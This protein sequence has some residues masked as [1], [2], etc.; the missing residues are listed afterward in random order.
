MKKDPLVFIGH[1][2]EC[3]DL[4]QQ[5]TKNK[6]EDDFLDSS[7]LQDAV[8]KRIE[9]IGEAAKNL[10][11]SFKVM[12]LEVP[13]KKITGMR[14]KLVH[15]YVGIDFELAWVVVQDDLPTLKKQLQEIKNKS[16]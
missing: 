16:V 5:Y 6:T 2:L 8:V 4:I 10:P 1:M 9:I 7:L 12:W 14:D 11:D 15:E 3:I 13:W